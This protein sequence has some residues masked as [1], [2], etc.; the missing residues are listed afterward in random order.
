MNKLVCVEDFEKVAHRLLNRNA[1]DYY[2]S[3]ADDEITLSDNKKGF[4]R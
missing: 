4:K 2:K 1:L 3:G